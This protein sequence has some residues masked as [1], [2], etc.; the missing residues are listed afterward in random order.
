MD[1]HAGTT[2]CERVFV[3]LCTSSFE[4]YCRFEHKSTVQYTCPY[5]KT[6][7]DR[8]AI[9]SKYIAHVHVGTV[10]VLKAMGPDRINNAS[11]SS[12]DAQLLYQCTYHDTIKADEIRSVENINAI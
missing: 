11:S 10:S 8:I 3:Y 12:S 4:N 9:N 5:F 6:V 1:G 7:A 2:V